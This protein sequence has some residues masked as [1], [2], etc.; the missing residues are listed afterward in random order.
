MPTVRAIVREAEKDDYR[1][2]S[3]VLGIVESAAFR[4][5]EAVDAR[6]ASVH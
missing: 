5:R 4:Q 1:F 6:Q 3:I 2:E